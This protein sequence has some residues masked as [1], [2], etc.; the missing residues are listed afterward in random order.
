MLKSDLAAGMMPS[1]SF[2]VNAVWRRPAALALNAV[3]LLCSA[4]YSPEWRWMRIKR[5]CAVWLHLIARVVRRGCRIKLVLGAAEANRMAAR[6]RMNLAMPRPAAVHDCSRHDRAT[7]Q[8]GLGTPALAKAENAG[9]RRGPD[10]RRWRPNHR[11]N[12]GAP[13]SL[14]L[15]A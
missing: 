15:P 10:V 4:A 12:A 1:G 7:Q 9:H 14:C 3:A 2:G 13:A 6:Q 5:I 8:G 11:E